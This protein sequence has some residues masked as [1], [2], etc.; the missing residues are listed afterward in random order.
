MTPSARDTEPATDAAAD[1]ARLRRSLRE[2]RAALDPLDRQDQS[3]ALARSVTQ[4]LERTTAPTGGTPSRHATIAAYLGVDPEPGTAPLLGELHRLGFGVVVPVCERGY[5][6]SW[7]TW[8]PGVA[9]ERSVRAP[10]FEPVGARRSFEELQDVAL[11]LVPAL[12]VDRSGHRIGQGGGYYDRFLA[13]HPLGRPGAVPRLGAVYR[14]EI[15]P[16]GAVPVEPCDQP[17]QGTFTADGLLGFEARRPP[18]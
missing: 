5:Q 3:R 12:A 13:R 15:L 7:T 17:L 9:L 4:Y 14:S 6:L 2:A 18:V 8:A 16:A 1:K 11:V 10:V